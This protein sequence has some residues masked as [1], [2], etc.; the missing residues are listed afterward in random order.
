MM[1]YLMNA[2]VIPHGCTGWFSYRLATVEEL[3]AF[4]AAGDV[5]ERHRLPGDAGLG[6]GAH[7]PVLHGQPR[8]SRLAARR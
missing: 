2:A 8:R 7:R 5:V 1:R 6:G 4:I 3:I